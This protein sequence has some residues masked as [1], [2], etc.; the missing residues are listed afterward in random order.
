MPQPVKSALTPYFTLGPPHSQHSHLPL[1]PVPYALYVLAHVSYCFSLASFLFEHE[2][3]GGRT[4][5][6]PSDHAPQHLA[7][8]ACLLTA[9]TCTC[10]HS[11]LYPSPPLGSPPGLT[12]GAC[13]AA[14]P[15]QW[16]D[17][18]L[19]ARRTILPSATH[20]TPQRLSGSQGSPTP[21][22]GTDT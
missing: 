21:D 14:P 18:T 3:H 5:A 4:F 16:R 11:A 1:H 6:C 9:S 8:T 15:P 22:R 13:L 17:W 20:S 7:Q 10:V 19:P 12:T 2:L